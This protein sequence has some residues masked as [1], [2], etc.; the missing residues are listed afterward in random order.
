MRFEDWYPAVHAR[1][2]AA[3]VVVADDWDAARDAT[4]EAL[5]RALERWDRVS[6]MASPDGWAYT[7]GVNLLRRRRRRLARERAT[8]VH[9][10]E[11]VPELSPEVWSVVRALPP[12]QR[13][14]VAL[15]YVLDLT[16]PEVARVMGIAVGTASATL[17]AARA[18]LR[19]LLGDQERT[20]RDG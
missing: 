11:A 17:G 9:V 14:A 12:R 4:D 20:A 6:V 18:G 13:E 16:E 7:V 3:L 15:R 1:L 2:F 8:V 10:E 19:D 5:T